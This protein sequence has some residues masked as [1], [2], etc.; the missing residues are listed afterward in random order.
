MN[1]YHLFLCQGGQSLL[2]ASK[3]H[4]VD[5]SHEIAKHVNAKTSKNVTAKYNCLE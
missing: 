2:M 4:S 1:Y 5:I 3:L